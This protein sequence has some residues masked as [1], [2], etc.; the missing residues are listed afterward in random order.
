[1]NCTQRKQLTDLQKGEIL[2]LNKENQS[3][4]TIAKTLK[5]PRP[6]IEGFLQRFKHRGTHENIHHPS[7]PQVTTEDQDQEL[8]NA[9]MSQPRITY[10]ALRERLNLNISTRTLQR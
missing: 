9:A 1:M 7:R 3:Q 10:N 8:C 2:A 5:I 6:T 4:R